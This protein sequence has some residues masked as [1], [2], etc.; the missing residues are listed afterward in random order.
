MFESLRYG[1]KPG[2]VRNGLVGLAGLAAI[3]LVAIFAPDD[4]AG[5]G[6]ATNGIVISSGPVSASRVCGGSREVAAVRLAGG[7]IIQVSVTPAIPLAP[8]TQV[9][10]HKRVA[11]CNPT[12]YEVAIRQ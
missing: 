2:N 8:G 10:V 7:Q 9:V 1:W 12:S 5:V 11:A 3:V 6:E 4:P